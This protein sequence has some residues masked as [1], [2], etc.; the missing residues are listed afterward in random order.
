VLRQESFFLIK[1]SIFGEIMN[2]IEQM[3]TQIINP[4]SSKTLQE[5]GRLVSVKMEEGKLELIYRRDGINVDQKRAI[6]DQVQELF[7]H[8]VSSDKIIVKTISQTTSAQT[9]K[10][11]QSVAQLKTGHGPAGAQK[12]RVANVKRV[13]AVAS[14]KGGVG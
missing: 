12:R 10:Q 8:M 5:E 6:E 7:G 2:N 11:A 14:G 13:I 3:A 9:P 1:R 4:A